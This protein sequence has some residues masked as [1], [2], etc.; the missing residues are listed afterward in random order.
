MLPRTAKSDLT[1][2][3]NLRDGEEAAGCG[4]PPRA[5]FAVIRKQHSESSFPWPTP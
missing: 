4:L 3:L 1:A 2:M 5:S